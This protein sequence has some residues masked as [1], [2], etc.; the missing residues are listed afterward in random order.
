MNE[1]RAICPQCRREVV[2]PAGSPLAK[3]PNCEF[4]FKRETSQ[5]AE[6]PNANSDWNVL[7]KPL[8]KM[9]LVI[10]VIMLVGAAIVYAG[11]AALLA[12]H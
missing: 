5:G 12:T 8:V 4:E 3:C 7:L 9:T 6:K 11:C 2:F 10:A 1:A